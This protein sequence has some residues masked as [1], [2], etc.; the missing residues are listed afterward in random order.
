[1][2]TM[3]TSL[4]HNLTSAY[5]DA[6]RKLS[7]KRARRRIVAY[8][9]SYDDIAFW[10]T[11]LSEFE[12]EERYFQVML[13]SSTSLAKGKKMVLMNTLNTA[14]LGRSLIACVDSDYD[15]LLQGATNVSRK[16]NRNPYIFQTYG[17]AIENFHCFADSLHEVCVQATLNDR[18]I[19]DFPAFLKRYSQIAYPLFLWNVWFYRQRDTHTFPMYD[20][21][22]CVRLREVNVRHPYHSLDEMQQT[23]SAKLSELQARFPQY[24]D[25][26]ERLGKEL[27]RLGLTP[28]TTYLYIQG[29]H[30]MD[31]VVL[32]VLTPVCT[33]LRREREEEI[34]RLAEHN[35]QFRNELTGYENSQVNV[36]LMLKKNSGYKNLYLYQW[37]REDIEEFL[38]REKL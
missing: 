1:M 33:V 26:V 3:A 5:L 14:E 36:S 9:E 2:I 25:R 31:C 21:N 8:V 6:A 13:P 37:L 35:E 23:V 30:I 27:E 18:S 34:K 38:G 32:K 7:P 4:K 12:N 10:R 24:I 17:Y 28:D 22:A 19:L 15:L 11:L 29:H 16:I 20:F